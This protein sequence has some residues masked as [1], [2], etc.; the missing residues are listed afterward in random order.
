MYKITKEFEFEAAHML[1]R[2]K[3]RS[4]HG[5]SYK[6]QVTI[7]AE[8]L[9]D[10]MVIDFSELAKIVNAAIIDKTD[11][12]FIYNIN[13]RDE[14]ETAIVGILKGTTR[15]LYALSYVPTAENMARHF[16]DVLKPLINKD[17]RV[18]SG[19]KVY[20]GAG[21]WAEYED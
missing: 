3:C 19:V 11:H 4:L 10:G 14:T 16:F 6:L 13:S 1:E 18:L 2:G 9:S 8:E 21:S 7:S 12:A 15:L 17:G 5:H 20:E